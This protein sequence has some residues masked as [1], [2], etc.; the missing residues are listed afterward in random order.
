MDSPHLLHLGF[1]LLAVAASHPNIAM[2]T[3]GSVEGTEDSGNPAV[4]VYHCKDCKSSRCSFENFEK[5]AETQD[6]TFS[7]VTIKLATNKTHITVCFEQANSCLEGVYGVFWEKAGEAGLSCGIL[8]S[9][10]NGKGNNSTEKNICCEAETDVWRENPPLKCYT[11]ESHPKPITLQ[12][13]IGNPEFLTSKNNSIGL[14]FAFMV[15]AVC[16]GGTI[17]CYLRRRRRRQVSRHDRQFPDR[18]KYIDL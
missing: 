7:N 10:E 17:M 2:S 12:I 13:S 18:E 16:T 4:T 3:V 1:L 6:K 8:N 5:I 9:G 14:L 11:Q 15:A